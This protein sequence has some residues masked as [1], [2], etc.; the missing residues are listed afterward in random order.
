MLPQVWS[1]DA[2]NVFSFINNG[3]GSLVE[4]VNGYLIII[5]KLITGIS[6]WLS[7]SKYPLLSTLISWSFIVFVGLVVARGPLK[8]KG[9]FCAAS[10]M[11]LIPSDP[12]VFGL[13]LYT[14]WWASVLLFT[15]VLW[16]EKSSNISLRCVFIIFCGLSSPVIL[17]LLPLFYY[18]AYIYRKYRTEVA[19]AVIATL[20][21]SIQGFLI[22][23]KD[24]IAIDGGRPPVF[25]RILNC[26]DVIPVFFGRFFVGNLT[27]N[28]IILWCFGIIFCVFFVLFLW[29]NRHDYVS[30]A[31]AYLLI[32]SLA[33]SVIRVDP[34]M[35]HPV[36]VGP[37]Y[38]FLPFVVIFWILVY[39][40]F[41]TPNYWLRNI[42]IL[43]IC[44]VIINS[45]PVISRIHDDIPWEKHIYSC[46][47]FKQY[48]IPVHTDG[49][50]PVKTYG[51]SLNDWM[52]SVSGK[53]C[54][55][56]LD[57]DIF[58]DDRNYNS[59]VFPYTYFSVVNEGIS[60]IDFLANISDIEN[61]SWKGHDFHKSQFEGLKVIGSWVNSDADTGEI[62]MNLERGDRILYRSGPGE[63]GQSLGIE[64][65]ND[66]FISDLPGAIDWVVLEFSN[67][68]LP[69]NFTVT[70]RDSGKNWGEWSAIGLRE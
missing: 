31:L 7:F 28:S 50:I 6:L 18:R 13:P 39:A 40:L 15:L 1:E 22:Y 44:F 62:S 23:F 14:L 61:T 35:L 69:K 55:L 41:L 46:L 34:S 9:K 52:V 25:D 8:L 59:P 48:A 26:I 45:I 64:G 66:Q 3:W 4:T 37:R 5:P 30:L 10:L 19:V 43:V 17:V 63:G 68:L 27:Q 58:F 32:C 33:L 12:E 42:F 2:W 21:A 29:K 36:L 60:S 54:K 16:D 20:I 24:F 11:F 47:K 57:R 70:L 38:F 51:K 56:L 53:Q 65:L 67:K 49:K